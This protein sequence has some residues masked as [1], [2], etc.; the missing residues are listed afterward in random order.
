MGV[1]AR[2][3]DRAREMEKGRDSVEK[4]REKGVKGSLIGTKRGRG[5]KGFDTNTEEVTT[6]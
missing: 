4:W 6:A 2:G 3:I 1:G 5:R